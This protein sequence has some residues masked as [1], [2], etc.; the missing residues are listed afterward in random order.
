MFSE[1]FFLKVVKSQHCVANDLTFNS[2]SNDNFL[3]WSKLKAF[4]DEKSNVDEKF[5]FVLGRV[6]NIVGKG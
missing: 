3:D 6:E 2:L 4:A 5:K 1:P